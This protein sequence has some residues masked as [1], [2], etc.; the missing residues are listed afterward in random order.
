MLD[1]D[2]LQL[3]YYP[4]ANDRSSSVFSGYGGHTHIVWILCLFVVNQLKLRF[5]CEQHLTRPELMLLLK[6]HWNSNNCKR[7]ILTI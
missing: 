3:S 5:G 2:S 4:A 7:Y 6:R 1:A